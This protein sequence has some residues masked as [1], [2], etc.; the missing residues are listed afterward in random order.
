L[1]NHS[2]LKLFA[3][4]GANIDSKDNNNETALIQANHIRRVAGTNPYF[5]NINAVNY[6]LHDARPGNLERSL[7]K[8]ACLHTPSPA[9]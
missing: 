4:A 9:Q 3:F 7:M 8:M 5:T 2:L 6:N 1:A